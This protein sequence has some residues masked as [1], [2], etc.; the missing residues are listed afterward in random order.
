ML[1]D[2]HTSTCG[3]YCVYFI[4]QMVRNV[5]FSSILNDF[6]EKLKRNDVRIL[7]LFKK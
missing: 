2:F 7:K 3:E 6:G 4:K 5:A 1:Q